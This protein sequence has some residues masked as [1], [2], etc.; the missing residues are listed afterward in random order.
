MCK[1]NKIII[2]VLS[3]SLF[4]FSGF[5]F[6]PLANSEDEQDNSKVITNPQYYIHLDQPTI[7]KG[8]TVSAF[9]NALKLSLTPGILN[10]ATGVDVMQLNEAM[11]MPWQ[12]DRIS[13]IYQFEFRNKQAYDNH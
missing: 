2:S 12:L 10:K 4:V 6:I 1:K 9:D 11:D 7:A 13:K 5:V 8:Y 3:L